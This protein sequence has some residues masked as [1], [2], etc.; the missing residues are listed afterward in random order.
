MNHKRPTIIDVSEAWTLS[1]DKHAELVSEICSALA[2][3]A[4][5]GEFKYEM[6]IPVGQERNYKHAIVVLSL[7]GFHAETKSQGEEFPQKLLVTWYSITEPFSQPKL[8]KF[9]NPVLIKG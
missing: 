8:G 7:L 9:R 4:R 5:K 2:D 3:E 6:D 1:A